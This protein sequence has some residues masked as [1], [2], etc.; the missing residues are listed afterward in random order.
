MHA[1]EKIVVTYLKS[2]REEFALL[3]DQKALLILE[4][5]K[6]QKTDRY[7]ALL[8]MHNIA[9]VYVL[10]NMTKY[11]Q[12]LDLTINGVAKTFLRDKF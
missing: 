2:K 9:A 5:F 11:F 10:A 7:R 12:P 8:E 6:G 4:V 3:P 1:A